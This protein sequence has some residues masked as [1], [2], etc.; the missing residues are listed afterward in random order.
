M[1]RFLSLFV[2]AS[3]AIAGA[4]EVHL[5]SMDLSNMTQ[6]WGEPQADQS[7]SKK[8]MNIAGK[9]YEKGIGTHAASRLFIELD[10]KAETFE[11]WVG[12]DSNVKGNATSIEFQVF[13]DG[14]RVF[15][16]GVMTKETPAKQVQ[17]PLAG[18]KQLILKVTDTDNGR[19]D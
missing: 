18:V 3:T 8:P 17:V 14:K 4:E 9:V 5:S 10:G 19:T 11:A 16:S 7:V 12:A 6:G 15:Q 2:A 13:A 1:R